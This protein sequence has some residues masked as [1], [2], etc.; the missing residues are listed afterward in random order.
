VDFE[1][2]D[3]IGNARARKLAIDFIGSVASPGLI[4][5]TI[6]YVPL[7]NRVRNEI[8]A[9]GLRPERLYKAVQ[10]FS[11]LGERGQYTRRVPTYRV[12]KRHAGW[13][14]NPRHPYHLLANSMVWLSDRYPK[15]LLSPIPSWFNELTHDP[16]A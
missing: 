14:T 9:M 3:M 4:V 1:V 8:V 16:A 5:G 15:P 10:R 12:L 6:M 7:L 13:V 2:L 11:T